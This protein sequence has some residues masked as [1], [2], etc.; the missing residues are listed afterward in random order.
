MLVRRGGRSLLRSFAHVVAAAPISPALSIV[1][2]SDRTID[3]AE[4]E[5]RGVDA[6][7]ARLD[8]LPD[9]L[10]FLTLPTSFKIARPLDLVLSIAA[11]HLLRGIAWRLPGFARSNLP[12]LSR[13]F[14]EFTANVEEEPAR[15][16]V[17]LGRPPLHLILNM[18]GMTRQ[19]YRLSWLDERPFALFQGE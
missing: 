15:R 4:A 16:V 18:T 11:Q 12:Y 8:K 7:L 6:I 14:L 13:N 17:R 9:E 2:V 3:P 19:S 10:E 1:D 5:M